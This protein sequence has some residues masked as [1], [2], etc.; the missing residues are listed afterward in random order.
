MEFFPK[1]IAHPIVV[2]LVSLVKGR[3]ILQ[4]KVLHQKVMLVNIGTTETTLIN[5][6]FW[7]FVLKVMNVLTYKIHILSMIEFAAFTIIIP[8]LFPAL[9]RNSG[10][11]DYCLF[12]LVTINFLNCCHVDDGDRLSKEVTSSMITKVR[13]LLNCPFLNN[14]DKE[15]VQSTVNN[16]GDGAKTTEKK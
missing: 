12:S 5:V 11:R 8:H 7:P 4:H 13:E 3:K 9:S 16:G 10:I 6:R 1:G 2:I 15:E 14:D